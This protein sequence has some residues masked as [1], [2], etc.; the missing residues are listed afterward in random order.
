MNM[1]LGSSDA[2]EESQDPLACAAAEEVKKVGGLQPLQ[3]I[4]ISSY[5]RVQALVTTS[6]TEPLPKPMSWAS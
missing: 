4:S 1:R 3:T 2:F 6:P 5:V